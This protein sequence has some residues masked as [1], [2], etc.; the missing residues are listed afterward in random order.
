MDYYKSLEKLKN[1]KTGNSNKDNK[2]HKV[3]YNFI[4]KVL[5]C[6]IIFISLLITVKVKP[7]LKDEIYKYVY[8]NHFSFAKVN[9]IYRKYFGSVLP[10]DNIAPTAE[11]EVFN[12]KLAYKESS[13]YKDGVKLDVNTN[14]LVPAMESGIVVFIGEKENYNNTVIIQQINGI[15]VWYGNV[16]VG[17]LKLYDYIQKGDLVGE[18]N[19][20]ELY[21]VFQKEGEF[22]NY[23]D[24]L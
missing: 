17:D 4:T 3:V 2:K 8:E 6:L 24:Y 18:T 23:K 10:F 13:L 1:K 15:D 21:L 9:E 22:L 20:K 14:Y 7:V 16:N 5:L 19:E 12:E 11:E